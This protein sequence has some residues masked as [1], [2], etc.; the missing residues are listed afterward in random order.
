MEHGYIYSVRHRTSGK[1]YVGQTKRDVRARWREH[2]RA[3]VK[4]A[5]THFHR[6]LKTYGPA[7]FT[8][9]VERVVPA[10]LLNVHERQIVDERHSV[11][12]GGLNA[13]VPC[14]RPKLSPAATEY[15]QL[16]NAALGASPFDPPPRS[17]LP[18][19]AS[20]S[21]LVSQPP[22]LAHPSHTD[23]SSRPPPNFQQHPPPRPS[24]SY[25][26]SPPFCLSAGGRSSPPSRGYTCLLS[27]RSSLAQFA[28]ACRHADRVRVYAYVARGSR[29]GRDVAVLRRAEG[30][31]TPAAWAQAT[32][33]LLT[34]RPDAE[35][36]RSWFV[37]CR[38]APPS[39]TSRLLVR[40]YTARR[41]HTPL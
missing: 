23:P 25:P 12:P 16:R 19:R 39:Y 15:M 29:R 35:L 1:C 26:S 3:S 20:R 4:R 37:D 28:R 27:A 8:W 13:L 38:A 7:S 5:R 11:W 33:F 6:A 36:T 18:S 9:A 14:G 31:L 30:L 2:L 40:A 32:S 10:H 21:P 41:P 17:A 22:P 34:V 24:Y